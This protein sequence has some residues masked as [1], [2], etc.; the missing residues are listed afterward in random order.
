MLVVIVYKIET[1][2]FNSIPTINCK[3]I[4]ISNQT[5]V[6]CPVW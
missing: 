5:H 2:A 4:T 3:G 6:F 1:D